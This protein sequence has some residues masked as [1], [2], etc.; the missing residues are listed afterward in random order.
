MPEDIKTYIP[1]LLVMKENGLMRKL[2]ITSN[3]ITS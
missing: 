1:S 3:F 2:R